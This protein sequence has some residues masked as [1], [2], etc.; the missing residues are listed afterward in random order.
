MTLHTYR[1][2]IGDYAKKAGRLSILQHGV[3]NLLMDACY[4]REH[5]PTRDE[6][7]DWVWASTTEEVEAV[8]FILRKF[9]AVG[10][11]GRWVQKRIQDELLEYWKFCEEQAEKGK[12]G[13]RPK[14]ANGLTKKPDGFPEKASGNPTVTQRGRKKSLTVNRQPSTVKNITPSG[15]CATAWNEW[16]EYRHQIR[17]KLTPKGIE[18]QHEFLLGYSEA[19]Q[20]II[21]NQSIRNE[22][23][24]L[25]PPKEIT[26]ATNRPSGNPGASG[27]KPTPAERVRARHA[28]IY[29]SEPAAESPVVGALVAVQ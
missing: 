19:D 11:D 1:R 4:D 15:I 25:F 9:F 14:K 12:K 27:R 18:K 23:A 13:G 8:D 6:A 21:I 2:H 24:G 16:V 3:Y 17:K 29:G 10:D 22:W 5:F 20:Q 7:V 28:E 26:H